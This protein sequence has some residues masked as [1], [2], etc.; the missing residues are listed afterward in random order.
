M[1]AD[2]GKDCWNII[3]QFKAQLEHRQRFA[4]CLEEIN[5]LESYTSWDYGI[6]CI[7]YNLNFTF[8]VDICESCGGYMYERKATTINQHCKCADRYT[9]LI[10]PDF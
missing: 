4:P 9:R 10:D 6:A 1:V 5:E 7:E 2:I 3:H 8:I